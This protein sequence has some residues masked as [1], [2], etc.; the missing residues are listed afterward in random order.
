MRF[1]AKAFKPVYTE[2]RRPPEHLTILT[3]TH[4]FQKKKTFQS[5]LLGFTFGYGQF[6][7]CSA[8]GT[9]FVHVE[10]LEED[11]L[12]QIAGGAV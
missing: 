12:C 1:S 4:I 11:V 7:L 9:S 2:G 8:S 5:L 3:L 6:I 10:Q